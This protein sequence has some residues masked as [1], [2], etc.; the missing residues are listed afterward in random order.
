MLSINILLIRLVSTFCVNFN[1]QIPHYVN[2]KCNLLSI[3][4][5]SKCICCCTLLVNGFNFNSLIHQRNNWHAYLTV[6][7]HCVRMPDPPSPPVRSRVSPPVCPPSSPVL[8]EQ[9]VHLRSLVYHL[10]EIRSSFVIM[11]PLPFGFLCFSFQSHRPCSQWRSYKSNA[12][13]TS[14]CSRSAKARTQ[15]I[16]GS[17]NAVGE[18]G[19]TLINIKPT[20]HRCVR[21]LIKNVAARSQRCSVLQ[22]GGL[23]SLG[24]TGDFAGIQFKAAQ[25]R[26]T[27][28]SGGLEL[29]H[30]GCCPCSSEIGLSA[31][32]TV[33]QSTDT[34]LTVWAFVWCPR[35]VSLQAWHSLSLSWR[36][37]WRVMQRWYF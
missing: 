11:P 21:T 31:D 5:P 8:S 4:F 18:P 14:E 25:L 29:Q 36:V 37:K 9:M 28:P 17:S 33:T 23:P 12:K 7:S 30:T 32:K 3:Q 26:V 2:R 27:L 13:P 15:P 6:L 35:I 16:N 20:Q 10:P 34:R 22:P 19:W 24:E 1:Y